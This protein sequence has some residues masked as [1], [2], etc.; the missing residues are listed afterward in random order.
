MEKSFLE[1]EW[2]VNQAMGSPRRVSRALQSAVKLLTAGF[3]WVFSGIVKRGA[4]AVS[5]A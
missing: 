1:W 5:S 4:A 2:D 3:L